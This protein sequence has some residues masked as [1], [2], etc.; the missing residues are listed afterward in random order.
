MAVSPDFVGSIDWP[1]WVQAVGSV[2]A[3]IISIIVVRSQY[4]AE[5]RRTKEKQLAVVEGICL[6]ILDFLNPFFLMCLVDGR[7]PEW[8]AKAVVDGRQAAAALDRLDPFEFETS[9]MVKAILNVRQAVARL[10]ALFD[11]DDSSLPDLEK[12]LSAVRDV[13]YRGEMLR[14]AVGLLPRDEKYAL[15]RAFDVGDG[16]FKTLNQIL[17]GNWGMEPTLQERVGGVT[18]DTPVTDALPDGDQA[19]P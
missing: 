19:S 2:L 9:A 3:I 13:L 7:R 5:R 6:L 14:S 1:A 16:D 4:R 15:K 10:L 17:R 8:I 11:E 12:L 18:R